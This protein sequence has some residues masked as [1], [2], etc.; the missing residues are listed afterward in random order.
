MTARSSTRLRFYPG[1]DSA[2]LV[3]ALADGASDSGT[4]TLRLAEDTEG[5]SS[6]AGVLEMSGDKPGNYR[7]YRVQFPLATSRKGSNS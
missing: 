7:I 2:P 6:V 5:Y 1:T 3:S 4:L